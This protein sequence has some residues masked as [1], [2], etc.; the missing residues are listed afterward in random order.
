MDDFAKGLVADVTKVTK[1]WADQCKREIRDANARGYRRDVFM[2]VRTITI[3]D[4]AWKVMEQAYLKASAGGTLPVQPRQIMYAARGY[5]QERT[6]KK[7]D[8]RYFRVCRREYDEL[9]IDFVHI[10]GAPPRRT[11]GSAAQSSYI[12]RNCRC[13]A[14]LR[15]DLSARPRNHHHSLRTPVARSSAGHQCARHSRE[16]P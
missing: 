10:A 15:P 3:Q 12:S 5:I 4:A 6:G 13:L 16:P 2:R 7:L 11:A 8:D 1:K 9:R 14:S